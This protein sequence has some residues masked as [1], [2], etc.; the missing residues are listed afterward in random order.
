MGFSVHPGPTVC[1]T[2]TEPEPLE[3]KDAKRAEVELVHHSELRR[4]SGTGRCLRG[5]AR[6]NRIW[7]NA[8]HGVY[9]KK[10]H[11]STSTGWT[12]GQFH[13][14]CEPDGPVDDCTADSTYSLDNPAGDHLS[15]DSGSLAVGAKT[16]SLGSRPLP[17]DTISSPAIVPSLQDEL[18]SAAE[19]EATSKVT[20]MGVRTFAADGSVSWR[21][22]PFSEEVL[23]EF[24]MEKDQFDLEAEGALQSVSAHAKDASAQASGTGQPE[25]KLFEVHEDVAS[26]GSHGSAR[27][28]CWADECPLIDEAKCHICGMTYPGFEPQVNFT[29]ELLGRACRADE[30]G[31][32]PQVVEGS[33][34]EVNGTATVQVST[35]EDLLRSD[36]EDEVDEPGREEA[37]PFLADNL[38]AIQLGQIGRDEPLQIERDAHG[39][40]VCSTDY[41]E[42]GRD[43][44]SDWI[45]AEIE[46]VDPLEEK[47]KDPNFLRGLWYED[48]I[49]QYVSVHVSQVKYTEETPMQMDEAQGYPVDE[50]WMGPSGAEWLD[51]SL[52]ESLCELPL[53]EEEDKTYGSEEAWLRRKSLMIQSRNHRLLVAVEEVVEQKGSEKQSFYGK[54]NRKPQPKKKASME[55]S[56]VRFD[57]LKF[58]PKSQVTTEA[59]I[60]DS[61]ERGE[62]PKGT[63]AVVR[64]SLAILELQ[65]L[66]KDL[67]ISKKLVLVAK[68]SSGKD[69]AADPPHNCIRSLVP[70]DAKRWLQLRI[71]SWSNMA[72]LRHWITVSAMTQSIW[73][74]WKLLRARF[75][76]DHHLKAWLLTLA[77]HWKGTSRWFSYQRGTAATPFCSVT[78]MPQGDS[79]AP[80]V[81]GLVLACGA[82]FV[83][84]NAPG[85]V[86][87]SQYVDDRLIISDTKEKVERAI[88]LWACFSKR[89]RLLESPQK[90]QRCSLFQHHGW[91]NHLKVLGVI[92]GF[93]AGSVVNKELGARINSA[94]RTAKR[95]RAL[96]LSNHTRISDLGLFCKGKALYGWRSRLPNG[97]QCSG[98]N[99]ALWQGAG[100]LRYAVPELKTIVGGCQMEWK[101]ALVQKQVRIVARRNDYLLSL[102]FN[103]K[104]DALDTRLDEGL[105][106]YGWY[107]DGTVKLDSV[108]SFVKLWLWPTGRKWLTRYVS[109][110]VGMSIN[111]SFEALAASFKDSL[112]R[113]IARIA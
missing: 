3:T 102:G 18:T 21:R 73:T 57:L 39:M 8:G 110:A 107:R 20:S 93:P 14:L 45:R 32:F 9:K 19:P 12:T 7:V 91:D 5:G 111:S 105:R 84:D 100:R 80:L 42:S 82:Q 54:E 24:S 31:F 79:S 112:Y 68:D 89:F 48:G 64:D 94:K 113:L 101:P 60:I 103:V 16:N 6:G 70:V 65:K 38:P 69:A 106:Y 96:P 28:Q 75:L 36:D 99:A 62:E 51:G 61:L 108:L 63:I 59:A 13:A 74:C 47:L 26:N 55:P 86:Y 67:S 87:L 37:E 97:R 95:V 29:C 92:I 15:Q 85:F 43:G 27:I 50:V 98:Y 109:L 44:E 72:T 23:H 41:G 90:L 58:A 56:Q 104:W 30:L 66:A 71:I 17:D 40:S 11:G 34:E 35:I 53:L 77:R 10:E 88:E 78:G 49:I 25:Q 81:L 1:W 52:Y 2:R 46:N 76:S 33:L 22:S 83:K 4:Y